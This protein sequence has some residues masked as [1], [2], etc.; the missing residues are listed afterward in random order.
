MENSTLNSSLDLMSEVEA[1]HIDTNRDNLPRTRGIP[2]ARHSFCSGPPAD[3][4]HMSTTHTTRMDSISS[5]VIANNEETHTIRID[6]ISCPVVA[7]H[8]GDYVDCSPTTNP[9]VAVQLSSAASNAENMHT[10]D[11]TVNPLIL[12]QDREIPFTYLASLSAKWAANKDERPF[13]QGKV[14]VRT[15]TIA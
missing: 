6:S 9:S 3:E 12:S 2:V 1:M 5:H 4:M 15:M 13:V 10:N 11:A 14:K 8:D 7:N